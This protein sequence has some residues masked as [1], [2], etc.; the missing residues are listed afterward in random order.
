MQVDRKYPQILQS[1]QFTWLANSVVICIDPKTK[2]AVDRVEWID[3]V[4]AI[5]AIRNVI[6]NCER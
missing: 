5:S 1:M 2:P 3:Q 4:V 6:E